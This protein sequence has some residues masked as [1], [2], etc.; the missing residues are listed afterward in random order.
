M[1]HWNSHQIKLNVM[2]KS[3]SYWILKNINSKFKVL[4]LLV[5]K[6]TTITTKIDNYSP[7][8]VTSN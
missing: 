4:S 6:S 3:T 2:Y 1:A 7:N 5:R 8:E